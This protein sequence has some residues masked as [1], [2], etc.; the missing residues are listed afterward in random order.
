MKYL[1]NESQLKNIYEDI[2]PYQKIWENERAT[3]K[4]YLLNFGQN[5][6]SRE[7]GKEYKV[8]FDS[9]LSDIIG[10]NY[11]ICIQY[12][13]MTNECGDIIYVRAFDKFKPI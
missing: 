11:C 5:M 9:F 12:N 4:R 6:I 7:N 1:I 3:L 8:I 10:F 13:S 2:N